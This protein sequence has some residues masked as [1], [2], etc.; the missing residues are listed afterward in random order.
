MLIKA[1]SI[2]HNGHSTM[3]EVGLQVLTNGQHHQEGPPAQGGGREG[4]I[5]RL[6]DSSK[7]CHLSLS[8]FGSLIGTI[9]LQTNLPLLILDC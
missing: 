3:K 9:N 2:L 4:S 5:L 1:S 7:H 8:F 6:H